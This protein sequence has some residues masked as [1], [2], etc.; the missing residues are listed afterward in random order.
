M[1]DLLHQGFTGSYLA[2]E[3]EGE[4]RSRLWDKV[5][6]FHPTFDIYQERAAG[7][8]IPIMLLERKQD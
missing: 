6:V 5:R 3:V 7:R 1:L 4:E 8:L 2:R